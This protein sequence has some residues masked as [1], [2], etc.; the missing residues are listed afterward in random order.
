V[1]KRSRLAVTNG[2]SR[3]DSAVGLEHFPKR[4]LDSSFP[5]EGEHVVLCTHGCDVRPYEN[6]EVAVMDSVFSRTPGS[7]FSRTPSQTHIKIRVSDGVSE[8]YCCG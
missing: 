5:H 3:R 8:R 1:M 7:D 6:L 2:F 4:D